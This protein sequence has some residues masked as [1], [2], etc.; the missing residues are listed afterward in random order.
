LSPHQ[1]TPKEV[2][3]Q[4]RGLQYHWG[5]GEQEYKRELLPPKEKKGEEREISKR[6]GLGSSPVEETREKKSK[7]NSVQESLRP[8]QRGRKGEGG[9]RGGKLPEGPCTQRPS[10]K[11][12]K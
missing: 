1:G 2:K 7:K 5:G 9:V 11:V 6:G 12:R 10:T 4:A 3:N 8:R